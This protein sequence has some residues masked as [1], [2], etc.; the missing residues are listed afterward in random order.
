A[1]VLDERDFRARAAAFRGAFAAAFAPLSGADAYYA[2]KA[3][4]CTE[5]ARWIAADGLGLDVCTGGELAVALRARVPPERIGLHGNNKSDA[6]LC[7]ALD[8]GVGRIVVD[9]L[10]EVDRLADLAADAG[11]RARVLLRVTV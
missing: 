6:E 10:D 2:G 8:A 11:V 7:R 1:Y 5:V 3:F 9:S 4:L